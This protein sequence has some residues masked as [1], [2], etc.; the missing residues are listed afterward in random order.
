MIMPRGPGSGGLRREARRRRACARPRRPPGRSSSTWCAGRSG[1]TTCRNVEGQSAAVADALP[2]LQ[3]AAATRCGAASTGRCWPTSR[4]S[5]RTRCLQSLERR[6]GGQP[7]GGREDDEARDRA[8]AGRARDAPAA[9]ARCR[10][11]TRSSR[12]GSPRTTSERRRTGGCS[13]RSATPAATSRRWPAPTTEARGGGS[14]PR[15]RAARGRAD[16]GVRERVWARLHEFLLKG[17]SD[18]LRMRLQ[19]LNPTTDPGYDELFQ[20]LVAVDGELRRLR[21]GLLDAD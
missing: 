12:R 14:R 2:I 1:A 16:A 3:S 6:L 13:S 9:R 8:G 15:G 21:Q 5:R 19:K 4:A 17:R 10:R 7:A 18:A 20:E 11:P